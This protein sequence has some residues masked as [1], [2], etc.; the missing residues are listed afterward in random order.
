MSKTKPHDPGTSGKTRTLRLPP[1]PSNSTRDARMAELLVAGVATNAATT[2]HYAM[3]VLGET[4]LTEVFQALRADGKSVQS[5]DLSGVE[6]LLSSQIVALNAIFGEMARRAA[7]NMGEHLD[8]TD[9]YLRLA[10][11]AQGQCRATAETL[12]V[13]KQGPPIFARQANVAHGPQQ[14]NNGTMPPAPRASESTSINQPEL[15]ESSDGGHVDTRAASTAGRG[16]SALEAVGTKHR[17]E[18]TGR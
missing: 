8:A 9:K 14:V 3:G 13:I 18:N 1:I 12:A 4:D 16:D 2:T 6:A 7:V 10:L 15:L 5:G 17:P 11:R